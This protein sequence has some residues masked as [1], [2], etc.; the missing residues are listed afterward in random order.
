ML[1]KLKVFVLQ[2]YY[3]FST[4]TNKNIKTTWIVLLKTIIVYSQRIILVSQK[5]PQRTKYPKKYF[6]SYMD[7]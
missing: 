1:N 2:K 3:F 7:G 5:H 4:Y 6:K